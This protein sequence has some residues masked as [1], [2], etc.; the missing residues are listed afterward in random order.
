MA[1]KNLPALT[2]ARVK[3][4]FDNVVTLIATALSFS[5]PTQ[6]NFTVGSVVSSAPEA[7]AIFRKTKDDTD[8]WRSVAT[9]LLEVAKALGHLDVALR[10][11]IG[12]QVAGAQAQGQYP[13]Q[14]PVIDLVQEPPQQQ[15]VLAVPLQRRAAAARPPVQPPQQPAPGFLKNVTDAYGDFAN[16]L[17]TYLK[18]AWTPTYH[19]RQVYSFLVFVAARLVPTLA[20]WTLLIGGLILVLAFMADPLSFAKILLT[21]MLSAIS[22]LPRLGK[23]TVVELVHQTLNE[24]FGRA[25]TPSWMRG[26]CPQHCQYNGAAAEAAGAPHIAYHSQ[27]MP[28]DN[29]TT[30]YPQVIYLPA[31]PPPTGPTAADTLSTWVPAVICAGFSL[32]Y[33]SLNAVPDVAPG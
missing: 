14:V 12:A 16:I 28:N 22:Q 9:A 4:L 23:D 30:A 2:G 32:V 17:M 11:A 21:E 7:V 13:Q 29:S 15:L 5:L 33:N 27:Q 26:H 3:F 10:A 20:L 25:A 24:L 1:P 18:D 6:P 19:I 31:S 8:R